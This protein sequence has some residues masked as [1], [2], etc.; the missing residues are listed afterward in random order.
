MS[1]DKYFEDIK[2]LTPADIR[3]KV[4]MNDAVKAMEAAF[5]SFS[6]GS[7]YVP[8]RHISSIQSL[9]LF[10]KPAFSQELGRIAVKIIT[11]KTDGSFGGIPTILGVVLLIDIKSGAVLAMMDG[12]Y[13]TA[14]RTG[15]ASGIA[16]K[17]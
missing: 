10:L 1:I 2:I 11:Q 17:L 13:I 14:L 7:C 15:A 12:S 3:G 5:S 6:N 4:N 9:N 8:Q 16:T